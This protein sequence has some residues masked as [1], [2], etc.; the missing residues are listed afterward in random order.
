ML[1]FRGLAKFVFKISV[2]Q[3]TGQLQDAPLRH[4]SLP[5]NHS[6]LTGKKR[7][8]EGSRGTTPSRPSR[9]P[10]RLWR[11]TTTP[12]NS[13][14]LRWHHHSRNANKTQREP[15]PESPSPQQR[16]VSN[17][18]DSAALRNTRCWGS[19]AQRRF[20]DERGTEERTFRL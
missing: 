19:S 16:P 12:G 1:Q 8:G 11:V 2:V 5:Q 4:T 6:Q 18:A 17:P 20:A 7:R 9:S 3:A 13:E 14:I 15:R 10:P